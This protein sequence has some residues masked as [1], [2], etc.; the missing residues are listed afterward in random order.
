M[1]TEDG[2]DERYVRFREHADLRERVTELAG[3]QTQTLDSLRRIETLLTA[4]PPQTTSAP[5]ETA[6]AAVLHRALEL[7][8]K[9]PSG[10]VHPFQ[11]MLASVG[12]LAIGGGFVFL[13]SILT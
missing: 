3:A 13:V 4:R 10:G 9:R 1:T 2:F 11:T 8:E 6:M 5:Q 7:A 12:L